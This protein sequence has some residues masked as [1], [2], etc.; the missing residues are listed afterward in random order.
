MYSGVFSCIVFG[1]GSATTTYE[2]EILDAILGDDN[3]TNMPDTVYIGLFTSEPSDGGGGSE[4]T[5]NGYARVAVTNNSTN[6]P[7]ATDGEK[8][9][10]ATITFPQATNSW[11]TIQWYGLF[12]ASSGGN[13]MMW[14]GLANSIAPTSGDTP[15]FSAGGIIIGLD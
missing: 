11:G 10:G 15:F 5:G 3:A 12:D 9:N 7:D 13:L 1:M 14:G 2:N 4:V 8:R 6:W